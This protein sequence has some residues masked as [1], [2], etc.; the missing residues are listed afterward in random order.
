MSCS[1]PRAAC[2]YP[3]SAAS[4]FARSLRMVITTLAGDGHV[5]F[6]GE[7]GPAFQAELSFP[8]GITLDAAGNLY[9]ADS[10]NHRVRRISAGVITTVLGTGIPGADLPTQLDTPT[11]VALD[12][13]GNLYVADSGNQRIQV[14]ST[15]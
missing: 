15:S 5:G 8:A 4:V 13:A 14:L 2:T 11:G 10:S 9:F 3:N 6:R 12:A 7:G 1:M